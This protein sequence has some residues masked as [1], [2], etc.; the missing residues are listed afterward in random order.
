MM[1]RVFAVISPHFEDLQ[2]RLGFLVHC[3][4]DCPPAQ[5]D[6]RDAPDSNIG[7]DCN[8]HVMSWRSPP[9]AQ[10]CKACL[11]ALLNV[12]LQQ[13]QPQHLSLGMLWQILHLVDYEDLAGSSKAC[14][15]A[16]TSGAL[17][18]ADLIRLVFDRLDGDNA[19]R[20]S[21]AF[22]SALTGRRS[23]HFEDLPRLG[24]LVHCQ[25]DSL[26][27]SL[28]PEM[29]QTATSARTATHTTSCRGAPHLLRSSVSVSHS[30][31]SAARRISR[32]AQP[33]APTAA[34]SAPVFGNASASSPSRG[35]RRPRGLLKTC[36]FEALDLLSASQ[37]AQLTLNS[38]AEQRESDRPGL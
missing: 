38:G 16:L 29:L 2:P 9:A 26:L 35:L 25:T 32:W 19:S 14:S 34:A 23:P 33:V 4:T 10:L 18:N 8:A 1:N 27:P 30:I 7:A 13:R 12:W 31:V 24:F 11:I 5:P 36:S 15:L 3:Q 28:T 6:S 22:L 17:N 37:V 20:M 21:A